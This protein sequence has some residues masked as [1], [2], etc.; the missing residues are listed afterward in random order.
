MGLLSGI[1]K[2]VFEGV[3]TLL[4]ITIGLLLALNTER[5]PRHCVQTLRT[6]LLFTVEADA[7]RAV[8]NATKSRPDIAKQV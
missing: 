2:K 6:N 1:D 4:M 7:E 5:S 8:V 3:V